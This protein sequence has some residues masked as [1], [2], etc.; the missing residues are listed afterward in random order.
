M[1]LLQ[2]TPTS[3][4]CVQVDELPD[5]KAKGWQAVREGSWPEH[6]VLLVPADAGLLIQI[7]C[8][9]APNAANGGNT[10]LPEPNPSYARYTRDIITRNKKQGK[11]TQLKMYL[12]TNN[13]GER[14]S[15]RR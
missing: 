1:K 7:G 14:R 6:K 11:A 10:T 4:A 2:D 8:L 13:M 12:L 5:C 9:V 3:S 15:S